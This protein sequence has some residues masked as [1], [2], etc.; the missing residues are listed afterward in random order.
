MVVI[1]NLAPLSLI[2]SL[3][4]AFFSAIF[5]SEKNYSSEYG[6]AII[7]ALGEVYIS[8]VLFI[9]GDSRVRTVI[10]FW[11]IL[12]TIIFAFMHTISFI[13]LDVGVLFGSSLGYLF[14]V[15]LVTWNMYKMLE[16]EK[17]R[18]TV[19]LSTDATESSS[20]DILPLSYDTS[21]PLF[22]PNRETV[23]N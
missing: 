21:N 6:C 16:N 11:L 12:G 13:Y 5:F 2:Y 8:V 15:L 14:Y 23:N 1:T 20:S 22:G 4:Y 9:N 3:L 19:Q 7:Y 18:T 17:T 10:S